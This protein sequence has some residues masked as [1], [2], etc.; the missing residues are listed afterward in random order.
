MRPD[1]S[2]AW[3]VTAAGAAG[4]LVLWALSLVNTLRDARTGCRAASGAQVVR[5]CTVAHEATFGRGME[6][7]LNVAFVAVIA[8]GA[9]VLVERRRAAS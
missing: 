3:R 8:L 6:A 1:M 5:L 2:R 4:G 9:W 7:W